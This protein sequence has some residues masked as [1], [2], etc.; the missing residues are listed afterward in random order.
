MPSKKNVDKDRLAKELG[1]LDRDGEVWTPDDAYLLLSMYLTG[2]LG[3]LQIAKHLKRDV[4]GVDTMLKSK[5]PRNYRQVIDKVVRKIH[6]RRDRTE[7]VWS[8]R[9]RLYLDIL[10]S[11]GRTVEEC[12]V[13]LARTDGCI[14][15]EKERMR[16]ANRPKD[17]PTLADLVKK[18]KE[19]KP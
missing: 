9:E 7:E 15:A 3:L 2:N 19:S 1:G 12:S 6:N 17:A 13:V 4:E 16:Q 14:L 8:P 18:A 11:Q 10:L 5:I